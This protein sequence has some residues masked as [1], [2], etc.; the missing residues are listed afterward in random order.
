MLVCPREQS[1]CNYP[2]LSGRRIEVI[3]WGEVYSTIKAIGVHLIK[4]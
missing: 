2:D 1:F 3:K 4:K